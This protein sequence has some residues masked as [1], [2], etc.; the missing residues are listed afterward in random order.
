MTRIERRVG[1]MLMWGLVAVMA[2][3]GGKSPSEERMPLPAVTNLRE[4]ADFMVSQ[5]EEI[6]GPPSWLGHTRD[7]GDAIYGIGTTRAKRDAGQD[8]FMALESGRNVVLKWLAESGLESKAPLGFSGDLH[9]DPNRIQFARI[10]FDTE[11]RTWYTLAVLEKAPEVAEAKRKLAEIDAQLLDRK[12]VALDP[13]TSDSDRVSAAL[14]LLHVVD[15]RAQWNARHAYFAGSEM[16]PPQGLDQASVVRLAQSVLSEHG[17]RI[18]VDGVSPPG[19]EAAVEAVLGSF[20]M[21]ADEFGTGLVLITLEETTSESAGME[22]LILDG[23]M[24][25]TLE[26]EDGRSISQPLRAVTTYDN[27]DAAR[28][29]NA[30]IIAEAATAATREAILGLI[31]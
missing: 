31:E 30:R 26:G 6:E 29:R 19:I 12:A 2:A 4:A 13:R 17:V 24:Q 25:I 18:I 28:A 10:A 23:V 5:A 22:L 1:G 9:Q 14:T 7:D 11:G 15:E 3:C 27:L 8:L 20:Y 21:A 16:A